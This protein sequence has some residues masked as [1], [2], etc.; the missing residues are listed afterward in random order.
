MMS[1]LRSSLLELSPVLLLG[2]FVFSMANAVLAEASKP[3]VLLLSDYNTEQDLTGWVMSEKLDGIRAIW[4]GSHLES[5]NGNEIHAP[6]WF[7]NKLPPFSLDGELWVGRGQFEEVASIVLDDVPSD[8]WK[9]VTYQVFEVPEQ[10]GDLFSRLTKLQHYLD[11]HSVAFVQV[12]PQT[13]IR[14]HAA[15]KNQ[16]NLLTEQGAEGLVI[17]DPSLEYVTGRQASI[18]KVKL[19][20]DAEC[21]VVGYHPGKG[22]YAGMVGSLQC[23]LLPEQIKRLFPSLTNKEKP[24]IKIGSGL[25]D[26]LRQEPPKIG[27]VITFQYFGLT[28]N[29]WP[30]FVSFLRTRNPATFNEGK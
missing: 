5:K 21:T 2:F 7:M 24:D 29:G 28:K 4:N 23:Q 3:Q 10:P 22:K 13:E 1:Q 17:R 19:K 20:Q 15:L 8:D 6:K 18:Q 26:K 11:K 27:S 12:I 16:L 30:R 9:K 14:S 25:S